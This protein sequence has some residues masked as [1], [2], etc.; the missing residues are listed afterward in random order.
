MRADRSQ[1]GPGASSLS[2]LRGSSVGV[3]PFFESP[4]LLL[5]RL[6]DSQVRLRES[7]ICTLA[8]VCNPLYAAR[9]D[10]LCY[11]GEKSGLGGQHGG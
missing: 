6:R 4:P 5:D 3:A 1:V 2:L 9:V 8:G 11:R 10:F 7:C